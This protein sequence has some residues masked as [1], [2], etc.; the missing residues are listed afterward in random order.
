M[1]RFT[2]Y[3]LLALVTLS[4]CS[5]DDTA[6]AD[7]S[8]TGVV[9][10]T[11]SATRTQ[12]ESVYDPMEHLTVYIYNN[13]G[14]LLRKYTSEEAIPPR[15]E[16]L[17]GT[18]R[19]AVEAG[20]ASPASTTKR[21]YKGEEKVEVKAGEITNAK[22]VCRIVNSIVEVKFD[23]SVVENFNAG[24]FAWVTG[25]DEF[26]KQAAE[27]G[28]VP[29]LKFTDDGTG[30]Y[31]LPEG[32]TTLSWMFSGTHSTR[33]KVEKTGIMPDV[34]AGG[35]YIFTFK[36]SPDLPGFIECFQIKVDTDTDDQDDT[37]IFSP[38]PTIVG[39]GFDTETLQKYVSGDRQYRITSFAALQQVTVSIDGESHNALE[40]AP[41]GITVTRIDDYNMMLKLSDAF[42]AGRTAGDHAVKVEIADADGGTKN[43][44]T[45]YRL[46][47]IIP[48]TD[49]SYDLWSNTLTMGVVNFDESADVEFGL[50]RSDGQ[51]QTVVGTSQGDGL[52]S[53]TFAPQWDESTNE[54]QLTVYTPKAGTGIFAGYTY[55]YRIS[56][57]GT[58]EGG[59][60]TTSTT[61]VIPDGDMENPGLSCFG[62]SNATTDFWG[63]GNN[64]YF[65]LA[66]LSELC[67]FQSKTGQGGSHCALLA[68]QKAL[69]MLAAGNLFSGTF[70]KPATQGTVSFGK[71][72]DW[73]ARPTHMRFKYHAELGGG[74]FWT[75]WKDETGNYPVTKK[76]DDAARVFV[77]IVDW[78]KTQNVS[79]GLA[80]PSGMWDPVMTSN[81][82]GTGAIIGY[83]SVFIDK[84]TEGD[85]M[86]SIDLPI[87]YYDKVT[88]PS[89][90]YKIVI[91][92]SSNAYG[93]YMCGCDGNRLYLD[94]F[95]WLYQ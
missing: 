18:Y 68:S 2:L 44:S 80:E 84:S 91:S 82:K 47:G 75:K 93:D 32:T 94:D 58:E 38:E 34:K 30:Y 63:S 70:V 29:A 89:K 23:A 13:E 21:Y 61:Q 3:L 81:I 52:Y 78:E 35:K 59:S 66:V 60:F 86:V 88:K 53:V 26:D 46:Q 11:I 90:Q 39:E 7:G 57:N 92:C 72:Y 41:A 50:R 71:D 48:V 54:G 65:N 43:V 8:G 37:I 25:D 64:N 85:E 55:E 27:A 5:K 22:V 56:V 12:D 67:T 19:F 49:K 16:L 45:A 42:F 95:E 17:A 62:L 73:Q 77:A 40:G 28:S 24:Y 15:L 69:I 20:E 10:M 14:G 6:P 51:W 9:A 33:G 79:S 83:G 36:Y 76:E 31:I 4:A 74:K 87:Y 1:K